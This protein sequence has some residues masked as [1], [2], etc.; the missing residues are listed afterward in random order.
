MVIQFD[1]IIPTNNGVLHCAYF[2]RT[3]E[4][5]SVEV[6]SRAIGKGTQMSIEK[7]HQLPGHYNENSTRKTTKQL[8]WKITCDALK[9][10]ENCAVAKA[11]QKNVHKESSGKRATEPNER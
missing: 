1:I 11:Q 10:C 9:S 5:T 6:V 4:V 7:A 2:K 8:E 3:G